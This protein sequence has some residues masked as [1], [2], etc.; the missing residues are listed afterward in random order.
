MKIDASEPE[1]ETWHDHVYFASLVEAGCSVMKTNGM[2]A[3]GMMTVNL[4]K[5][6]SAIAAACST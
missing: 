5:R 3:V 4:T 1:Q 2:V 6:R